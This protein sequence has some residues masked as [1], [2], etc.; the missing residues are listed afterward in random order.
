V[1]DMTEINEINE[2]NI[3]AITAIMKVNKTFPKL[4]DKLMFDS[5]NQ[6]E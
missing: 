3:E 6:T 1:D 4:T 2:I 5:E